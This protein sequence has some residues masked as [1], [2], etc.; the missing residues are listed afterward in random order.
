MFEKIHHI[1][2]DL[3]FGAAGFISGWGAYYFLRRRSPVSGISGPAFAHT[4]GNVNSIMIEQNKEIARLSIALTHAEEK[5]SELEEGKNHMEEQMRIMSEHNRIL[6][7]QVKALTE[8]VERFI[9]RIQ[10]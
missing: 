4:M 3:L 8:E 6:E 9:T 2:I 5:I 1:L 7:K 10:G